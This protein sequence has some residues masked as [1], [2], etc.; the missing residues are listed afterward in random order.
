[1]RYRVTMIGPQFARLEGVSQDPSTTSQ[2]RI[3]LTNVPGKFQVGEEYDLVL[4][5]VDVPAD[6]QPG[7]NEA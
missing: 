7:T 4:N 1:M 6:S 3:D 2:A 5:R